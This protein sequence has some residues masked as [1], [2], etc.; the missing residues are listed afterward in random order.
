LGDKKGGK[1]WREGDRYRLR[2]FLHAGLQQKGEEERGRGT[3]Q[4]K[5]E[6]R[7]SDEGELPNMDNQKNSWGKEREG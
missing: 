2:C 4:A 7:S 3:R 6:N 5:K 1:Q